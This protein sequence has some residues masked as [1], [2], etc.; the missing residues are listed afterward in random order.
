MSVE[1]NNDQ[2]FITAK[3]NNVIYEMILETAVGR[4]TDPDPAYMTFIIGEDGKVKILYRPYH[5]EPVRPIS[6]Y[7]WG[8]GNDI[9]V[10]DGSGIYSTEDARK[11][12]IHLTTEC[13]WRAA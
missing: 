11:I 8:I 9:A 12:W 10:Q 13:L 7:A 1:N 6:L 5:N 4:N 2:Q 3:G